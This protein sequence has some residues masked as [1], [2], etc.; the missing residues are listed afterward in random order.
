MSEEYKNFS[1]TSGNGRITAGQNTI[2]V[3]P[4]IVKAYTSIDSAKAF[5]KEP[6]NSSDKLSDTIF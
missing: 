3:F 5:L 4:G 2:L 1:K 6:M